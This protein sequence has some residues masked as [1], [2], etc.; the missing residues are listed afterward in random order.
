VVASKLADSAVCEQDHLD[1]LERMVNKA[2]DAAQ[3]RAEQVVEVLTELTCCS[4]AKW[5]YQERLLRAVTRCYRV[6]SISAQAQ[7]R[8]RDDPRPS[9]LSLLDT[10]KGLAPALWSYM[11]FLGSNEKESDSG[12]PGA[13]SAAKEARIMPQVVYEVEKFEKVLIAAQK[14]TRIPLLRGIQRNTARDYK[15]NADKLMSDKE[16]DDGN[17]GGRLSVEKLLT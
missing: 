1:K 6:L 5:S 15:I 14:Y 9:F 11:T 4:I 3:T 10:S 2:E 7:A 16:S 8:R 12:K 17:G 13:S